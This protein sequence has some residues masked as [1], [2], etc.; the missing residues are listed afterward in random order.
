MAVTLELPKEIEDELRR[1]N[2]NL[3]SDLREA[4]ALALFRKGAL[5]HYQL[6]RTLGLDRFETD[7]LLQR[8]GVTEQG[9]T[10][11][12]LEADS[13][14]LDMVLGPVQRG[15]MHMRNLE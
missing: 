15:A 3:D 10:A 14:A 5:N 13:N 8:N 2:P 4:C 6:S 1:E 7:A 9:L 11:A 12:D